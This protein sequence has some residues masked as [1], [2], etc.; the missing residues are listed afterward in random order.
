MDFDCFL[1]AS[2]QASILSKSS[3][4]N[5]FRS[6]RLVY[7]S[8]ED[9]FLLVDLIDIIEEAGKSFKNA[10]GHFRSSKGAG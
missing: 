5:L 10:I 8:A 3:S 1:H 2:F 6:K 9:A 7:A 4:A